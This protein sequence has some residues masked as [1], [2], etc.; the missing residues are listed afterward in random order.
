MPS[1]RR[2]PQTPEPIDVA[3]APVWYAL[4]AFLRNALRVFV[5]RA[6]RWHCQSRPELKRALVRA[7]AVA[8]A[9][10]L[11]SLLEVLADSLLI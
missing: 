2:A 6:G 5:L 11:L 3:I 8:R 9:L 4:P 7:E 10:G 1:R